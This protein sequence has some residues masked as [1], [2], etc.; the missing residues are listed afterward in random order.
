MTN[1]LLSGGLL[2]PFSSLKNDHIEP[3]LKQVIQENQSAL[4]ALLAEESTEPDWQT[5]IQVLDNLED[6]LDSLWS[7]VSHLFSVNNSKPLREIYD[8]CQPL[9]TEYYTSLS[10]NEA[11]YLRIRELRQQAEAQDLSDAQ[12]KVLDDYLLDFRLAGVTLEAN[13][14]QRFKELEK[15]LSQLSTQFSNNVLDATHDWTRHVTDPEQ[16]AGLPETA[17][18]VAEDAARQKGLDGYLLTLDFPCFHAVTT[19][20]DNEELRQEIYTAYVT[21]ASDQ[22]A[23]SGDWDNAPLIDQILATRREKADLLSF[24]SYADL[25]LATKMADSPEAVIQFLNELIVRGRP[26]AEREFQELVEFS[27]T[28]GKRQLNAWDIPYYS[29]KLRTH[30]Y[31][32]SQEALR[33]YFPAEKVKSGLFEIVGRLF[34]ISVQP[35]SEYETW[36]PS[37]EAYDILQDGKHIARVFL[38]LYTRE[39]KRSG[40]WMA[41]CRSRRRLDDGSLQLPAAYLVC[42]FSAGKAGKPA[43][44]THSEVTTLFHEFGHGL[45]HL[46][47]REEILRVSGI[48]GVAWDAVELP[49]QLMENWCWNPDSIKLISSHYQTGEPLPETMLNRMLAARNFQAGLRMMRQLEFGLFDFELH[50]GLAQLGPGYVRDT[51]QAVREKTAVYRIPDFN[52]FENSFSHIFAGGYAAGYYSYYWAEVLSADVFSKF[53]DAGVLDAST[54]HR[55]LDSILSRGGAVKALQLFK[56]F[57]GREPTIDALLIQNGM[58]AG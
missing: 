22:G 25:S 30:L 56:D 53:A 17:L 33:A 32:I 19:Y 37:V 3:A 35:N 50:R 16:L 18:G 23:G 34:G 47:T 54:G 51:M 48:H 44:L 15:K 10:Q 55:Y 9:V 43:L 20:A 57:M 2:P 49:S 13:S 36:H 42:N 1:P 12:V 11:L 52:R 26:V 41:G 58:L 14:K 8:R 5:L 29:E 4:D 21:R 24:E 46:L 39:G 28:L 38:D 40:A 31:D 27:A 7:T 6:R 45:H